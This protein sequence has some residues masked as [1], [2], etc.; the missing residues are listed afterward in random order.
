MLISMPTSPQGVIAFYAANKLGAVP[1]LIHPLSTAPGDRALPRRERRAHRAH[2]R[3]VLRRVRAAHAEGA[4]RDD[5]PRAHPRLPLAA[6]EAR[7]LAHQGT[8][9]PAVPADPRVRWW[10]ELMAAAHPA[11]P[12]AAAGAPTIRRRSC[13]PAAPPACPRASCCRTATSS[14]RACR[15]PPGAAWARAIRSSRSCRSS[16]ASASACA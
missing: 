9:D 2:A 12:R 16:T 6:Q 11:A 10:A 5:H 15:P 3:R 1:A 7:L 14:P 13:S 8:Q 4:A